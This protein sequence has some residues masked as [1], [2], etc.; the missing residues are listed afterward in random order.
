MQ[1]C[2]SP[3]SAHI[4]CA[5]VVSFPEIIRAVLDDMRKLVLCLL[6]LLP[7]LSGAQGPVQPLVFGINEGVTYRIAASEVR[8]RYREI[9][10]DLINI[11][12]RPVRN[13]Y[14]DD[15]V[16]IGKTIAQ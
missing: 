11:L 7:A 14:M 3:C 10:D 9:A 8:E 12:M 1:V 5:S 4:Q 2:R 15:Y 6:A 13:E 16:Q